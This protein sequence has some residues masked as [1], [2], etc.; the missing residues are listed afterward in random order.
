MLGADARRLI[1]ARGFSLLEVLVVVLIGAILA[2]LVMLRLGDWSSPDDSQRQ[3]ERLAALIAHQCEQ[4]VFQARP[5]GIRVSA[6]G[7]D[8][9]QATSQGW[10]PLAASGLDRPRAWSGNQVPDLVVEGHAADLGRDPDGPQLACQPL[11]ELTLFELVLRHDGRV[12]RLS[13][14]GNGELIVAVRGGAG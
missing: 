3:L 10:V 5:R 7:Y 11:G 4:A 6:S 12:H 1:K 8:F 2:T 13:S 9:W 14:R